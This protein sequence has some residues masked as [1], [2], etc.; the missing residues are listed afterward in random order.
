MHFRNLTFAGAAAVLAVLLVVVPAVVVLSL[1]GGPALAQN[2]DG[3]PSGPGVE[4]QYI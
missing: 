1:F 4:R 2:R 3:V